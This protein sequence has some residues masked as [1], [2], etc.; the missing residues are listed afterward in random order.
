MAP[1]YV[2]NFASLCWL[3]FVI[4]SKFLGG[5]GFVFLD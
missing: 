5:R 1:K 2:L 3:V 4:V